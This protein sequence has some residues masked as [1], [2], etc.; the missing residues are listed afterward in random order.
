MDT[1]QLQTELNKFLGYLSQDENNLHLLYRV[2]DLQTQLAQFD[3]AEQQIKSAIQRLGADPGLLFRLA[4]F[5]IA[6]GDYK[7]A[8]ATLLDMQRQGVDNDVLRYNLGYAYLYTGEYEQAEEVLRAIDLQSQQVPNVAVVLARAQHHLNKLDE[9]QSNL[10]KYLVRH[11]Q[12]VTALGQLAIISLDAQQQDRALEYATTALELDADSLE[13][14]VVLGT[15]SFDR[16]DLNHAKQYYHH[17]LKRDAKNARSLSGLGMIALQQQDFSSA[18]DYLQQATNLMPNDTANLVALAWAQIASNQIS[19]AKSNLQQA[20][21]LDGQS[22]ETLASLALVALFEG[23]DN[24]ASEVLLKAEA[25]QPNSP[26]VLLC[27][28]IL[29]A[30]DNLDTPE[31]I[32]Q[33]VIS[34]FEKA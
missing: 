13:A 15:I 34:F 9:A 24:Q 28:T 32:I 10:E 29:A 21:I 8:I 30:G 14:H 20:L 6:S 12:D 3:N 33:S 18:C 5:S 31:K 2:I 17:A 4:T 1:D 7:Q 23:N 11:P 27:K 25:M 19:V 16:S 26:L 22:A